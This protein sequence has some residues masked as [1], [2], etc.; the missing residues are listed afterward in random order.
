MLEHDGKNILVGFEYLI[1]NWKLLKFSKN[2]WLDAGHL[3]ANRI[4][5]ILPE[6]NCTTHLK[7]LGRDL[8]KNLRLCYDTVNRAVIQCLHITSPAHKFRYRC[9]KFS[10]HYSTCQS[11]E[12]W[13]IQHSVG[14]QWEHVWDWQLTVG[15]LYMYIPGHQPTQPAVRTA[16]FIVRHVTWMSVLDRCQISLDC[17]M[18]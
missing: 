11:K 10:L 15:R 5:T 8:Q 2:Y 14:L 1:S 4:W 13:N 7:K 18:W 16:P 12:T 17:S 3:V 9:R 6:N